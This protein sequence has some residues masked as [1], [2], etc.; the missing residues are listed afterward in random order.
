MN[1]LRV[2]WAIQKAIKNKTKIFQGRSSSGRM[3][4]RCYK[5]IGRDGETCA[6]S[7]ATGF[8]EGLF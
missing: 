7:L 1:A 3:I 6:E 2:Y 4:R 8:N 5:A